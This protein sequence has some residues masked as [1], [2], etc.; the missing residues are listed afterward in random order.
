MA[1][2]QVI[3]DIYS[4]GERIV[5]T[6]I[7]CLIF[8]PLYTVLIW[9]YLHCAV[10]ETRRQLLITMLTGLPIVWLCVTSGPAVL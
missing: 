5:I 9:E 1:P 4:T 7:Y 2:L 6:V 10:Y 3:L 8:L